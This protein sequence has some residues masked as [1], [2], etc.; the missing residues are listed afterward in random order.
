[1]IGLIALLAATS[2][3]VSLSPATT[4]DLL[5]IGASSQVVAIDEYVKRPH[6][7]KRMPRLGG[8]FDAN[9]ELVLAEQPTLV[10][11]QEPDTPAMAA[12]RRTRLDVVGLPGESLQDDWRTILRVGQLTGRERQA[13]ALVSRLKG[14]ID[15]RAHQAA[16]QRRLRVL[17]LLGDQPIFSVARGS[18]VDDLLQL[19]NL[20]NV[21]QDAGT[22]WPQLSPEFAAKSNPDV[23]IVDD[24]EGTLSVDRPP[25][26]F[27]PAAIEHRI[28][29]VRQQL[30][31][32]PYI[33][34]LFNA[35]LAAVA[36]Y[37]T[38]R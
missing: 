18:F 23:L 14:N 35:I 2:R 19:A 1:M 3:I 9:A 8:I 16:H 20:Q 25:W 4:E 6:Q 27:M 28:V 34:Q 37:R 24:N 15:R 13:N 21:A 36:P 26:S 11:F 33:D 17:L 22:P 5:E 30:D 38:A 12:L 29:H 7:V 10:V 31:C 32:G